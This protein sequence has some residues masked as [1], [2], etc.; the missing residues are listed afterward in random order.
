MYNMLNM[1]HKY[2]IVLCLKVHVMISTSL[3]MY[4]DILNNNMK[5]LLDSHEQIFTEENFN[6]Y[7]TVYLEFSI[8]LKIL[9]E[10][11]L[12]FE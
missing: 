3:L 7:L 8:C 10:N 9:H 1:W 6:L 2:L 12:L 11:L 5:K 4:Y